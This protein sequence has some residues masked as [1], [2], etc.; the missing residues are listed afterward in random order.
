MTAISETLSTHMAWQ[1][2]EGGEEGII[3]HYVSL[4]C[5]SSSPHLQHLLTALVAQLPHVILLGQGQELGHG[6][7][8][9]VV[10]AVRVH[11]LEELA[12]H[13]G[14]SVRHLKSIYRR[15]SLMSRIYISFSPLYYCN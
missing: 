10:E 1:K 2:E 6:S 3:R 14:G 8:A 5:P 12:H 7:E 15:T 9:A 4:E 13:V 11:E